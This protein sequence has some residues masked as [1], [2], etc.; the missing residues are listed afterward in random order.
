MCLFDTV[1]IVIL[2][3]VLMWSLLLLSFLLFFNDPMFEDS[4]IFLAFGGMFGDFFEVLI[5]RPLDNWAYQGVIN[6]NWWAPKISQKLV[7][8]RVFGFPSCKRMMQMNLV[9]LN[10]HDR[11]VSWGQSFQIQ[12][13]RKDSGG[14]LCLSLRKGPVSSGGCKGCILDLKVEG[15]FHNHHI[16][17]DFQWFSL[18]LVGIL[19]IISFSFNL[20]S[21]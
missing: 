17:H 19:H 15:D 10:S 6:S 21:N 8:Y 5:L 13:V 7:R 2:I 9:D 18:Y 4:M 16:F 1:V 14:R 12:W 20:Q 11:T 3:L